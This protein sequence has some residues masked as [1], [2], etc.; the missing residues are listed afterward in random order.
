MTQR[1]AKSTYVHGVD[2]VFETQQRTL[3]FHQ[4]T[5]QIRKL[6][7][8]RKCNSIKKGT[9]ITHF[10]YNYKKPLK[11]KKKL[12]KRNGEEVMVYCK[13]ERLGEFC[14][15]CGMLTHTERYCRK[16]L[17]NANSE[18]SKD[19]GSWLRAQPRRAGGIARSRW[20]R[21]EDDQG[22]EA[23]QGCYKTGPRS[24]EVNCVK[25]GSSLISGGSLTTN[26]QNPRDDVNP[27]DLVKQKEVFRGGEIQI[28]LWIMGLKMRS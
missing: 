24:G 11:R 20:L 23:R 21:E 17:S 15:T 14:F 26:L 10:Q 12:M 19:W 18:P 9:I 27:V 25:G 28:Y 7:K 6:I 16:F 22:W 2:R 5:I 1:Q 3:L 8:C 13:Y 4:H